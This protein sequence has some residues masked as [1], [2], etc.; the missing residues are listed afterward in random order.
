MGK[1]NIT[2]KELA[3]ALDITIN[4]LVDIC[5][6][7]DSDDEDNWELTPGTHFEWGLHGSRVFSAE[8]AVEICNYLEANQRE[9]PL[10]KRWKRWLLQRDQRLK[11][12]MIAKRVQEASAIPGQL[13]FRNG[14]AFLAPKACREVLSLGTR[15]DVLWKAFQEIQRFGGTEKESLKIDEDF[16]EDESKRPHSESELK[17]HYFSGSGLASIS[18]L[19]GIRLTKKHRQEWVK[20]V[21]EYAPPALSVIEKHESDRTQHIKKVMNRVRSQ[22]NGRCQLTGRRKSVYKFNLVVHHLFDQKTHPQFADME[23]NLIAIGED[24]HNH[25][26]QWMGGAHISCTVEDLE[27]YVEEFGNSLFPD[28]DAK[29]AT[30]A[31]MK[32]SKAKNALKPLL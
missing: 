18:K 15:Q 26:H 27:R 8:G 1:C 2:D 6:F 14:R 23:I 17:Y 3:E 7:F 4:K 31:A 25:F 19:L 16:F 29:Q 22:A 20:T 11:G 9:R 12:L 10:L 28:G 5:D 21:A 24:I 30:E 32:L 13:V